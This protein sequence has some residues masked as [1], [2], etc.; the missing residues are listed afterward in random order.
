[1][2]RTPR[3]LVLCLVCLAA[4][5]VTSA[6]LITRAANKNTANTQNVA[7]AATPA[8]GPRN[9][10]LQPEALRVSRR[11]G[12][13]FG[14]SSRAASIV[15]GTLTIGGNAQPV[16]MTRTQTPTGE[17]VELGLSDRRLSWNEREGTRSNATLSYVERLLV[18]RLTLDSPDQFVLAQLRGASYFTVA[19]MVRPAEAVDGYAG[20]LWNLVRVDERQQDESLRPQSTW[21]I[22]YLNVQTE[23]PDRVEYQLNGQEIKVEFLE[24]SEQQGEKT[25]SHVRW[26]SNSQP[27]MEYRATTVSHNQ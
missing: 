9:L 22:Y 26:T 10:F 12:K 23:L 7:A 18:E 20:P 27:V 11:L 19:R 6:F 3:N 17:T 25:P 21:R 5:S 4:V 2:S 13:R 8:R 14:P 15:T 16:S 24:W 1:M